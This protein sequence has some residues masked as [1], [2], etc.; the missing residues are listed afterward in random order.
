MVSSFE[1]YDGCE[2]SLSDAKFEEFTYNSK[3]S[4]SSNLKLVCETKG[5]PKTVT[6][7]SLEINERCS[8]KLFINKCKLHTPSILVCNHPNCM[9]QIH[10]SFKT[11]FNKIL[12]GNST[13]HHHQQ[14]SCH[15]AR[16]TGSVQFPCASPHRSMVCA[17]VATV[18]KHK[19]KPC[20][21]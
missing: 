13:S 20:S 5:I 1:L 17:N 19:S 9:V 16:Y 14:P 12:G 2:V 10:P 21:E 8:T 7:I 6:N 15:K 11:S 4:T 18:S 3:M